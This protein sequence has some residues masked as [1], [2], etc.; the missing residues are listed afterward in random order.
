MAEVTNFEDFKTVNRDR[1]QRF[2]F[3]RLFGAST[4]AAG[5]MW[6][7]WVQNGSPA[8]GVAPTTTPAVCTSATVGALAPNWANPGGGEVAHLYEVE[9]ACYINNQPLWVYDRLNH[10]GGFSA[11]DT[12]SKTINTPAISRGDTTGE[13]VVL[14]VECYTVTGGTPRNLTIN[15][16]DSDNNATSTVVVIP[17]S[18]RAGRLVP[19]PLP[20]GV[21]GVRSVQSMQLDASTG[22]A[23]NYGLTMARRIGPYQSRV[24]T[25]T[26]ARRGL[27]HCYPKID[28]DAC[29]WLASMTLSSSGSTDM[30]GTLGISTTG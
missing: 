22:T 6:S 5:N 21:R 19:V 15:F 11:T 2:D 28:A 27:E 20:S 13:D 25:E 23:G 9:T 16:T 14:F 4:T 10:C 17:A 12:A 24:E 3:S 1:L 8:T 29:L 18:M 26:E 7:G 30:A